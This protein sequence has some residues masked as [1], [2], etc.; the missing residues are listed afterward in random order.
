VVGSLL[1][2]FLPSLGCFSPSHKGVIP[3]LDDVTG[4]DISDGDRTAPAVVR[5]RRDGAEVSGAAGTCSTQRPVREI[6][7]LA[8]PD[9]LAH[10]A[11]SVAY[12]LVAEAV[13]GGLCM[14]PA[15]GVQADGPG[16]GARASCEGA[17]VNDDGVGYQVAQGAWRSVRAHA[18]SI[19]GFDCGTTGRSLTAVEPHGNHRDVVSSAAAAGEIHQQLGGQTGVAVPEGLGDLLLFDLLGQPVRA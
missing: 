18:L 13:P 17:I 2:L 16:K 8:A 11:T 4:C 19:T 14:R 3:K 15:L 7:A 5:V 6:E 1:A 12:Y 10:A 9:P